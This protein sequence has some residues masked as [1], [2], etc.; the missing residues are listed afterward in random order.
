[1]EDSFTMLLINPL[2]PQHILLVILILFF[3][4]ISFVFLILSTS[5]TFN[6]SLRRL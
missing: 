5:K 6:L 3:L 2:L 1:M 4:V